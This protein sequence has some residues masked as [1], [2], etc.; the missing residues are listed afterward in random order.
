MH[1]FSLSYL[2]KLFAGSFWLLVLILLM[3]SGVSQAQSGRPDSEAVRAFREE[4]LAYSIG[5]QA[6]LYGYPAIDYGRVMREQTTAG[7]DSHGV[8]AQINQFF[9]QTQLAAPGGMY[10]GRA[11]N[12]DTLYFTGWLDLRGGPVAI[13]APDTHDRYYALTYADFYS[14]VQHTGRRTTG[15]K[16][17]QILVA[18]PDWQGETPK[19]MQLIRMKTRLA[20]VLGRV[21]VNGPEDLAAANMVMAQFKVRPLNKLS[22]DRSAQ[23]KPSQEKLELPTATALTTLDFFRFLNGFLRENPRLPAEE[24]L[25]AQFDLVGL[26]PHVQFDAEKLSPATRKG[27]ERALVDGRR[28]LGEAAY[29]A[30]RKGWSPIR[31]LY[32]AYGF[33]YLMR[34][35]VEYNGFLGN[36]PEES[37]YPSINFDDAGEL[38]TGAKAYRLTFAAD[39]LP[40]VDAFWSL[41]AYDVRTI[42]LI[43][44]PLQRYSIGDRSPDLKRKTD[45][46]IEIRLQKNA[47]LETDVNW[48]P[49]GDGPF[50]LTLRMYQPRPMALDGS[51]RLPPMEEVKP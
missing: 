5:L 15:T 2:D 1:R 28:I 35:I 31:Q 11:P 50:F 48:L 23:E 37:A 47:P 42:D 49:V 22:Q 16:A 27:L 24:V 13:D 19:G 9:N 17:Q 20:Y 44:N 29:A 39:A 51:Y 3:P 8:Y 25:M 6:Y 7:A 33:N 30:P 4:Q 14:E 12:N 45:G 21:V 26:G 36:L 38:L 10:A 32:G 43:P 40:P 41:S 46:S 18:G 34:A